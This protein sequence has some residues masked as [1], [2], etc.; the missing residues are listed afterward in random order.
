[1]ARVRD[2]CMYVLDVEM[3]SKWLANFLL[4][5]IGKNDRKWRQY[6]NRKWQIKE[7]LFIGSYLY[8]WQNLASLSNLGD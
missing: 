3:E 4:K 2:V 1:M 8:G 5:T 7:V 6:K